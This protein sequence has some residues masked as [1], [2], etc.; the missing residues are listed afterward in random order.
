MSK[1]PAMPLFVDAFMAD[2]MHLTEAEV[3]VYM[4]LLMCMWRSEGK[5]PNDD[6]RLARFAQVAKAKW[7]K[8][9]RPVLEVFFEVSDDFLTQKRLKKEWEYV[10]EKTEKNRNSGKRGGEAKAR[11]NKETTLANAT[12]TL[13]ENH[14]ERSSETPSESLP[15]HTHTHKD[16][17][18]YK[19]LSSST[20]EE[21]HLAASEF[22]YLLVKSGHTPSD[23][24]AQIQALVNRYG[25]GALM[26]AIERARV[27]CAGVPLSYVLATLQN[28]ETKIPRGEVKPKSDERPLW[29]QYGMTQEQWEAV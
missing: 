6:D 19:Y 5:L 27:N 25:G 21:I 22:E 2:T 17:D 16:E 26:D 12:E 1:A 14:S 3:G 10:Q 4:R 15:T 18:K 13:D 11:K 29:E 9:F 7:V 20:R 23:L 8:K 28:S 24:H